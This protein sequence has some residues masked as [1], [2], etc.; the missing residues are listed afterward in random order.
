MFERQ[1]YQTAF[2][3]FSCFYLAL[4]GTN[5]SGEIHFLGISVMGWYL[6]GLIFPILHHTFT[7]MLWRGELHHKWLSNNFGDLSFEW[8]VKV[9]Y[10]LFAGRFVTTA[11]VAG[12]DWNSVNIPI[13]LRISLAIPVILLSGY[14]FYCVARYFGFRRAAGIDHFYETYRTLPLVREGI[15]NKFP[16]AMY[17]FGMLLF[18]LPGIITG[19]KF[20]LYLAAYNHLY[21]WVHY[22][23]T[24]VPDMKRMYGDKSV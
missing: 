4:L 23:C 1:N 21:V 22:F 19:S 10:F 11:I 18:W 8:F 17:T 6:L 16:N 13:G 9:F 14:T 24:E 20:A 5:L 12:N 2:T 15:F 3:A 7:W